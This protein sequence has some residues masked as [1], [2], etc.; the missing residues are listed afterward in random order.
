[1]HSRILVFF[2]RQRL[3]MTSMHNFI[4]RKY[5][6][7]DM[8]GTLTVAV[9]D[10][11]A[12]RQALG[13]APGQPI[14]EAIDAL[15]AKEAA[16]KRQL[17]DDLEKGYAE[18]ASPMPMAAELLAALAQRGVRTGIVTR[19]NRQ[20]ATTILA[21]CGF[22]SYFAKQNIVVREDCAPK[23][24]PDGILHLL[25]SWGASPSDAVMLGDY[26]YDLEAGR[27]AG[28]GT[29]YIDPCGK[30]VWKD[31]ADLCVCTWSELLELLQ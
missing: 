5:W 17:L 16:Q 13:I 24:A 31:W 21:A 11:D 10:F 14:L 2:Q 23:P 27:A 25:S 19:N 8:D 12:M 9:H 22:S 6:I 29:V 15:S 4:R 7:F 1:M 30:F 20:S 28:T 3:D 18:R 26:R